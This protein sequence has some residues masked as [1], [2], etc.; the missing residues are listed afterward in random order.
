MM[1]DQWSD[2]QLKGQWTW[3]ITLRISQGEKTRRAGGGKWIVGEA[4]QVSGVI[5]AA[6]PSPFS[7]LALVSNLSMNFPFPPGR[8]EDPSAA[9]PPVSVSGSSS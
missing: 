7:G 4:T 3:T 1:S 2:G 9:P 5:V 6:D 8:M